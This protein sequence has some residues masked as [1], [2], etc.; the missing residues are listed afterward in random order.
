VQQTELIG[1]PL[2]VWMVGLVA[3]GLIVGFGWGAAWAW[4]RMGR[5]RRVPPGRKERP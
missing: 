3:V 1:L 5:R 2:V 4:V